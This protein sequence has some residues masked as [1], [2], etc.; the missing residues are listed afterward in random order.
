MDLLPN[1]KSKAY[2]SSWSENF[3]IKVASETEENREQAEQIQYKYFVQIPTAIKSDSPV[4]Y[5]RIRT[6]QLKKITLKTKSS[7]EI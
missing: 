4:S 6:T 2:I 1:N 3:V 5:S 7:T